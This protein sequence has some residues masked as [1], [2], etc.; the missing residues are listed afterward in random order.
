MNYILK[1]CLIILLNFNIAPIFAQVNEWQ[2]QKDDDG[3][4][5][6]TREDKLNGNIEFKA[7]AIYKTSIDTI[8]KVFDDVE[9]YTNWMADTKVSKILKSVNSSE[10]YLYLETE[11]PWPL[12]NRD[13]PF[14]Q[15]ITRTSRSIKISLIGKPNYIAHMT[16]IIRIEKASGYWEFIP[17]P[18]NKV[19]VIYQLSA[20][21]GLNIP[22]WILNLFVV[23][24][25]FETLSN[26]KEIV[27]S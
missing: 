5:I 15:K 17:L 3:I 12:K 25:P 18:N 24:G 20:D 2:L 4:I 22:A 11:V 14:Y 8:L 16:G 13:I 9:G 7:M 21:P 1:I 23:D 27:E 10:N 19:K 6:Y 26:L